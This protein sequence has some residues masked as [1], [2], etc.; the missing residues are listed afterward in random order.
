MGNDVSKIKI[1]FEDMQNII[2]DKNEYIIINTLERNLQNWLII[3]TIN[4]NEEE[5]II[6]NLL[7]NNKNKKIVIY[8]KNYDDEKIIDKYQQL[9]KLG[10]SS[11][12]IYPGGIFEWL[13]LQDI[14]GNDIF[15]TTT[16]ELDILKYKPISKISTKYLTYS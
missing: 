6:N 12:Y 14:Y 3:N 4:I 2:S 1:N 15:P 10:F 11:I 16:L 13:Q 8:G 5:K 9:I 7:Y